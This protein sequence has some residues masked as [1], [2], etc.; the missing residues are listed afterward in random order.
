MQIYYDKDAN[1]DV[2]RSKRIAVIGYGSQGFAQ[3]NNLKE[4]GCDVA[5]G[6]NGIEESLVHNNL[7]RELEQHEIVGAADAIH[8]VTI[9]AAISLSV[10]GD[11]QSRSIRTEIGRR[12]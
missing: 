6:P 9:V 11:A 2:L 3:S 1:L 5:V 12:P 8:L 10:I 4:S 7:R